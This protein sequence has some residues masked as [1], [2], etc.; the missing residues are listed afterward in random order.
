MDGTP[1]S[2][3]RVAIVASAGLVARGEPPFRGRDADFRVIPSNTRADQLLFSHI[4][5]NLDRTG[6]QEDWNVVF[7]LD[8][9]NEFAAAGTID[10]VAASSSAPVHLTKLKPVGRRM[11]SGYGNYCNRVAR[12]LANV[13]Q[14]RVG[15]A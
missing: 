1:L 15:I 6:F 5:I 8:R 11:P 3:R 4:S 14:L 2:E 9:L 10:S 7:P 13:T 12:R